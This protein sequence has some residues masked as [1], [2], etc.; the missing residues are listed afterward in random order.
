MEIHITVTPENTKDF[1]LHSHD[2][3]ELMCYTHGKGYL[4]CGKDRLPFQEGTIVAI[5]P[6]I[7]HGSHSE[8]VFSNICIHTDLF[9]EKPQ[10]IYLPQGTAEAL[11]LFQMIRKFYFEKTAS[12]A[13]PHLVLALKDLVCADSSE[14]IS[15]TEQV[16]R[17]IS[18]NYYR[19][20]FD[21]SAL[22]QASG[23]V[24]DFFRTLFQRAY[25]M[26]PRQYLEDLRIHHAC[27]LI[28]TYKNT[29][30]IGYIAHLS[31][32]KDPLYFS[33]RFK[34]KMGISP[35]NYQKGEKENEKN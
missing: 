13:I 15:A 27:Q 5:P 21:L 4:R 28:K 6:G 25:G 32:F 3:W 8:D 18:Q 22:I 34:K 26:T 31:G 16:Y 33:R 10:C 12:M 19:E 30:S 35:K 7:V 24:D 17:G 23:Y 2:G 1:P 14:A 11:T 9:P 20:D 29:L